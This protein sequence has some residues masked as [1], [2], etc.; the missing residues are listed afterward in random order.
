M[1]STIEEMSATDKNVEE[2]SYITE[3][4][5]KLTSLTDDEIIKLI[6][7]VEILKKQRMAS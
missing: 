5:K 4:K 6:S 3:L 2:P 7:F 1:S